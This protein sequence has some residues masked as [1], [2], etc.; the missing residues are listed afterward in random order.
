MKR[1]IVTLV[2]LACLVLA[3]PTFAQTPGGAPEDPADLTGVLVW[4]AGG[5][6]GAFVAIMLEK[7]KWFQKIASQYKPLVVLASIA[8]VA[9]IPQLLLDLV[10]SSWWDVM[11]PY[12]TTLMTAILAGY[13]LSQIFHVQINK[14][15]A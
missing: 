10:P 5:G 8:V 13:P 4:L 14:R 2:V 12:F 6:A 3:L 15:V 1:T 7:Q 11:G 9:L